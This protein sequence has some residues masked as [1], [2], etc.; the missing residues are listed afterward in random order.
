MSRTGFRRR[1]AADLAAV[2]AAVLTAAGTLTAAQAATGPSMDTD[3]SNVNIAVQGPGNSLLLYWQVNGASGWNTE[4][5]AGADTTFSAPSM[6]ADGDDVNIA[7]QGPGNSLLFYW[8]VNGSSTWNS[9]TVAGADTTYSAPSMTVNGDTVNIA[10]QG[11]DHSLLFYWTFNGSGTWHAETV[12]GDLTAAQGPSLAVDG[13]TFYIAVV[14]SGI[15]SSGGLDV[16]YDT[17]GTGT[18]HQ[19]VLAQDVWGYT[20][21]IT[22]DGSNI[23]I[24]AIGQNGG[25]EFYWGSLG[26][27]HAETVAGANTTLTAPSIAVN[28]DTV[29]IA[30]TSEQDQLLF[31]SAVIGTGTWNPETVAGENTTSSAPSITSDGPADTVNITAVSPGGQLDFYWQINGKSTWNPETLPGSGIE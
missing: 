17:I 11:P 25:I 31:Y 6:N 29:T 19:E 8:Q 1:L 14:H 10:V 18:W 23:N 15:I 4:T 30:A 7:V 26:T 3:G 20:P 12:G 16:W 13:N 24:S 22:A 28:G 2:T 9:E 5:V 27:W 21:A